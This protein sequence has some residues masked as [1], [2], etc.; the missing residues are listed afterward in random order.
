MARNMDRL[1]LHSDLNNFY[2]SV[3]C[4]LNPELKDQAV[5]VAGNP[6]LR[7]GVV[8]AK[9]RKAKAAGIKTGDVI[10]QAKQKCP[11]VIFVRPHFD[12]YERFSRQV[13]DIYTKFTPLVEPFGPDECWLDCTGC[14]RAFGSGEQIA[15]KILAA[16]KQETGLT[17]SVG[18]S[19]TKS[20]A[21]ICSDLAEPDDFFTATKSEFE[22]KLYS[23][24][25]SALMMVGRNTAEALK[26]I[27]VLTLGDLASADERA[28]KSALGIN[29]SKLRAAARGEDDE[30]VR[31]ACVSRK[32]E[33]V[34]HG[35]TAKRDVTTLSDLKAIIDYLSEKIASRLVR[36][37]FKGSGIHV[38]LRSIELK[39]NSKQTTFLR[40]TYSALDISQ[41]AFDL[42]KSLIGKSKISLRT[43]SVAVYD[44]TEAD[45]N[46][47]ISMFEKTDAKHDDLERALEK[48]RS[49]Y[50][51]DTITR[52]SVLGTDFIYDKDDCEDFL[53]FRR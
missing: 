46:A 14:E 11:D 42:A 21:K 12:L 1:I 51:K 24:P 53:P 4:A 37:G 49:K 26:K 25:A 39:H 16:V 38:D 43:I 17:V 28:L 36:G 44:L 22:Q 33:S 50:G 27:N 34:G 30:R 45:G 52:A 31:E 9:N 13:F 41:K 20:L 7:H 8:L 19:F 18:V 32:N 35:M 10:W 6:E 23:L 47:Q 29:G 2:A 5:A 40:P 3:E 15:R 48:I